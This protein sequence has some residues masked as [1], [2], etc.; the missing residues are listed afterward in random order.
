[1]SEYA[2]ELVIQLMLAD[3]TRWGLMRNQD[4]TACEVKKAIEVAKTITKLLR[5][6]SI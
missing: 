3:V 5:G 6:E 1:M 2:D 4:E